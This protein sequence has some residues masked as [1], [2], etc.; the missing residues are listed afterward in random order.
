MEPDLAAERMHSQAPTLTEDAAPPE[1]PLALFDAWLETAFAE[2]EAGRLAEPTAMSLAT[3]V[4][5]ADGRWLPRVRIVLLK[6]FD[7]IGFTFFT[8]HESDKGHEL[9]ANPLASLCLHWQPVFRQIRIEGE[10]TKVER[11]AAEAYFAVRP[12][13][14]QLS[15]W[16]C[17]QSEPIESADALAEAYA[18]AERRF[19]GTQVPCPPYWG[20]YRLVPRVLEFWQGRPS[21]MH[22]RLRYTRTDTG[23]DRVRLSP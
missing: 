19:E 18:A 15:A 3:A 23:W 21:R 9:T 16:A 7:G 20:G 8:N 10:I 14:F 1:D 5:Q 17:H 13:G 11:D 6:E 22:D 4:E 12:H 2:R